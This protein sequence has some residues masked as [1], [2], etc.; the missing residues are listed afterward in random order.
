[1]GMHHGILVAE[2]AWPDL[3]ERLQALTG[4]FID[5]GPI[6]DPRKLLD[7]ESDDSLLAGEMDGRAYLYDRSS[8]LS[9][10]IPDFVIDVAS[11]RDPAL[12]IGCGAETVSGSYYL[13]AARGSE[14]I[15]CYYNCHAEIAQPFE[16][17]EALPSEQGQP[18]EDLD[19]NG[20]LAA[21]RHFGFD[22]EG[23]LA[24][25]PWQNILYTYERV[26][27]ED[28]KGPL[29]LAQ[30]EHFER[31]KLS[32]EERPPLVVVGRDSRGKVVHMMDTGVSLYGDPKKGWM[33]KL[34]S[35]LRR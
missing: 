18:L 21:L 22:F 15:R 12:V 34:I 35:R 20:L 27:G 10:I 1:M 8:V 26:Y 6:S 5:R 3:L 13:T 7:A 4:E 28:H 16:L 30:D 2:L 29:S 19:G 14:L 33:A 23:W 11:K 24:R 9:G 25:G 31:F 32:P 17:G